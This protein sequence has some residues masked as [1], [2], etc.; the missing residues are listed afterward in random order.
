MM[1]NKSHGTKLA[2]K[3]WTTSWTY[4]Q[5]VVDT[6]RQP[7]LILDA[8][9]RIIAANETFYRVFQTP[10]EE[11][12]NRLLYELGDGQ[13]DIPDLRK[14]LEDILPKSTF[15]NGFQVDHDFPTIGRKKMLLNA[16]R[17]Y[18]GDKDGTSLVR[19]PIIFLA[20]EDITELTDIAERLAKD[21]GEYEASMAK[22]T[23]ELEKRT[24]EIISLDKA[25]RDSTETTAE[26]KLI[27]KDLTKTVAL[28][29][30][31]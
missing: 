23:K 8:D 9:F 29:S 26:L 7:F 30:K 18:Q 11:T 15:F 3:I 27:I 20:I 6:I 1:A 21:T 31:K 14:L 12:E 5:T 22:Q 10:I 19:G 17:V 16:R 28:S 4:I 25:M 2:K 24:V 13:W